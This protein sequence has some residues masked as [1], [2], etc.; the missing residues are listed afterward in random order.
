MVSC[1]K[2]WFLCSPSRNANESGGVSYNRKVTALDLKHLKLPTNKKLRW[3]LYAIAGMGL[4][5]ILG[6]AAV[7]LFLTPKLPDASA[8]REMQL[9]EPMYVY[10]ADGK[11]MSLYG[12]GRR[13]PVD[14][15]NVPDKLKQAFISIEDQNF[16]K[17]PGI[18]AKGI[19]RAVWLLLTTS[20]DRVPGGSTITQ[21]VVRQVFLTNDYS[22]SR[23]LSEIFLAL[24]IERELSKDE[25]FEIYLNK[26]FFGNRAYGV[27]A[28]A[29]FYYGKKLNELTLDE[30]ASLAG[31]PK[32]PSTGN[33]LDN[34]ERAK[35]RR[36]YILERMNAL[37]YISTAEMQQAQNA[38][39]HAT[40]HE[41]KIEVY[42]PYVAE[43][44]RQE[45]IQRY[46]KEALTKGLHITTT[47]DPELQAAS[48]RA[49][50]AGLDLYQIRHG[51]Q[52]AS[53]KFDLPK[54][55]EVVETAERLKDYF[56]QNT[57]VPGIVLSTAGGK[58]SIVLKNGK[59]TSIGPGQG[60][61]GANP[62]GQLKR[63]DLAYLRPQRDSSGKVINP[64]NPRYTLGQ[65]PKAQAALISIDS[66]TG[67][68]RALT[69][70]YSFE[71]NK[72]NRATQ[73][74]RQPG[75]S[76]KPF[77]YAAALE[78]GMNPGSIVQDAPLTLRM[79]NG[80]VWRP[81]NDGG[82][83]SGPIRIRDALVRSKNLVSIRLL[84]TIGIDY[85][86]KYISYFGFD[87]KT[88]PRNLTMALGTAD[89]PPLKVTEGFAAFNNG[90]FHVTPWFIS[91]VRDR[92]G[93]VMY[94]HKP[95]VA[96]P[97][98]DSGL[99]NGLNTP[100]PTSYVVDG[101]NF[102]PL[103]KEEPKADSK[104][105]SKDGKDA[106]KGEES[107]KVEMPEGFDPKTA[108]VA[109]RAMDPRVAYQLNS[110]MRDVVL[111]GTATAARALNRTDVG[112]KTG[113]T[114]E[115]RDAWF[116]GFGGKY[117]TVVWVGRDDFKPL[118]RGEYGGAA[119][120]PIWINYMRAALK[121]QQVKKL[122]VP[123]GMT[124]VAQSGARM[125]SVGDDA[126]GEW[127]KDEDLDYSDFYVDFGDKV[128]EK[129]TAKP[130]STSAAPVSTQPV[131][132]KPEEAPKEEKKP[133]EQF[134]TF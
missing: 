82:G 98:C 131:E 80:K 123:K 92:E 5:V 59:T 12:E 102:G 56:P 105:A 1:R 95:A 19:G 24:K 47:V 125:S 71:G 133:E 104:T 63:G 132:A 2:N 68:I 111:R 34:P 17:H 91:E 6:I 99:G 31:V 117:T 61:R 67:E 130:K 75:S 13:Y 35:I 64:D 7:L 121:D 66:M 107:T 28:A 128:P 45:M 103:K 20:D 119:A 40:P 114:N 49:V 88:I 78:R 11:L 120:L 127:V 101:F 129:T 27:G 48:D 65:I 69:G 26:S 53:K 83:F 113:S 77:V 51:W 44:V 30:M 55:E 94:R 93:T 10:S 115:H 43:M 54:D 3:A 25:I 76:F 73:A 52:G 15:K 58:V 97:S 60:W 126:A 124:K 38:P 74:K 84:K 41:R 50:T 29:E 39:M 4:A 100:A 72:F 22:Y 134:E 108:T 32:F 14:I 81:Q 42:A 112:G 18:D 96:C 122:E 109:P 106:K 110:M 8:L 116:A 118:G 79:G 62:A 86:I 46:G 36:D 23:K 85:A 70:G 37:G 16:Y 33:P 9:E 21:Q 90:G 57:M 87:P 89:L